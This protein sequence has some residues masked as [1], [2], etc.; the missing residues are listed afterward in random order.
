MQYPITKGGNMKRK[1]THIVGIITMLIGSISSNVFAQ[2]T[3]PGPYYATPSWDQQLPASTRFIV[4]ANWVDAN[5]P[6]GGAAVLDRETGL[7]W[8]RSPS[9]TTMSWF[10]A[11]GRCNGLNT[12]GRQGWRLPQLPELLSLAD[13]SQPAPQ[14]PAGHPFSGIAF[15]LPAPSPGGI[16]FTR[17]YWSATNAASDSTFAILADFGVIS[18]ATAEKNASASGFFSPFAWCVRGP[19]GQM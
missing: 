8:E 9:Q 10:Q 16:P 18:G 11:V 13:R 17:A 6:S 5:F 19:G 1:L 7:V 12:G 4:L 2:T 15:G 14:L 3:A